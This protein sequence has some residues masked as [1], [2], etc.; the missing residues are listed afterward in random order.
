MCVPAIER[1]C[2]DARPV[3]RRDQFCSALRRLPHPDGGVHATALLSGS[4]HHAFVR[5]NTLGL[6]ALRQRNLESRIAVRVEV[7]NPRGKI[8]GGSY[9]VLWRPP[10][11]GC[12]AAQHERRRWAYSEPAPMPYAVAGR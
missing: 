6:Q 9:Q 3:V 12:R 4:A 5:G 1:Q 2:R 11:H 7:H 10:E 8:V